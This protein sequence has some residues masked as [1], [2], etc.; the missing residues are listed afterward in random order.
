MTAVEAG[1][2]LIDAEVLPAFQVI[3][4]RE[5]AERIRY[6][7]VRLASDIETVA[8]MISEA[9]EFRDWLKLDYETWPEYCRAEFGPDRLPLTEEQRR[10]IAAALARHGLSVRAVASAVRLSKSAVQRAVDKQRADPTVPHRDSED[11]RTGL[12]GRQRPARRP[13]KS[14]AEKLSDANAQSIFDEAD[15]LIR[16]L[17]A[18]GPNL[19]FSEGRHPKTVA[20]LRELRNAIDLAIAP[21]KPPGNGKGGP[22]TAPTTDSQPTAKRAK[23][24]GVHSTAAGG[25]A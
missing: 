7:L 1:Q 21:D 19:R 5:R 17:E 9:Y 3:E 18:Y 23:A 12:D 24:I 8:S 6:G 25:D 10:V 14:G 4:A 20:R 2:E 16:L 15:G 13:R 11:R 22:K